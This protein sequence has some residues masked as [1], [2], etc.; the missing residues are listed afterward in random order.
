VSFDPTSF[1]QL[2]SVLGRD[3]DAAV[4]IGWATNE[5]DFRQKLVGRDIVPSFID[6]L[7]TQNTNAYF[8]INPSSHDGKGRSS[9]HEITR[10]VALWADVDFK[11]GGMRNEDGARQLIEELTRA[12]GAPPAAIVYSGGGCQPYWVLEDGDVATH[13]IE[14]ISAL[15]KRWGQ[16][17]KRFALD[18]GGAADGVFDLARVFRIP[19]TINVKYGAARPVT[20]EFAERRVTFTVQEVTDLLDE[21]NVVEPNT[22]LTGEVISAES[23]WEWADS[24]CQMV[25]IA[26]E[27]ISTS[28]PNSRHQ[29]SLKWS[30]ILYGMIRNGCITEASFYRLRD[31]L[32]ERFRW[33][34]Q[35][36]QNPRDVGDRELN[37]IFL[38]GQRR[39]EQWDDKKLAEEL[40]FHLHASFDEAW[41]ELTGRQEP[42][43]PVSPTPAAPSLPALPQATTPERS[44]VTSIASGLPVTF[45]QPE[46][47]PVVAT[48]GNLAAAL[49]PRGI[50]V[51][52]MAIGSRTDTGNAERLAAKFVGEFIYVPGMAWMRFDG[53][54][55]VRDEISAHV[56]RAKDVFAV[57]AA[58]GTAADQKWALKSMSSAGL[59][60]A[61]RLAQSTPQLA[62]SPERLDA[63][64]YQLC[65][66]SGI[67]DLR[68]GIMRAADPTTDLHT[69]Q[70]TVTPDWTVKP[71][72]FLELLEWMQP[73]PKIRAYLQRLAGIALIGNVDFQIFPIFIGPG[74]N[75]KTTLLELFGGVLGEYSAVMP[76]KFLVE[77]TH[78]DHP[79]EIAQLRGVRLAINSEVPATAKFDEDFVKTLTGERKLKARY[80][81]KDFF[82]FINTALQFMAA[83]HLPSVPAGGRGFWRR[84][85]K[86]NFAAQISG[87]ENKRLVP[88]LLAHEGAAI[89]AWMIDGAVDVIA[90]GEQQPQSVMM[91]TQQ[92]R[93]EEDSLARF[94]D[95]SL[96]RMPGMSVSRDA[97]YLN[98]RQW[99]IKEGVSHL[100]QPKFARELINQRPD[101][102]LE[103]NDSVY[104]NYVMTSAWL[105]QVDAD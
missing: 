47:Q 75:G 52:R 102:L 17:V 29:W 90:H 8:E 32:V 64:E 31:L 66:P 44:N 30:A 43:A 9:A 10:L 20:V 95:Q 25:S 89:L 59:S 63:E 103:D 82:D 28:V 78:N 73:D 34:C 94:L 46:A 40:R 15:S 85:R 99:A 18:L 84:V 60:A 55:Y 19:G 39:A 6:G 87:D 26:H 38:Y 45:A 68:T 42:A 36:T 21:Y 49:K 56:E 69:R 4:R 61:L 83:N 81:G 35:N 41:E 54:R 96:S 86:I 80:M 14:T 88:D 37:D 105:E 62:V 1:Y 101:A 67:V 98:Y 12:I 16:L 7:L 97:L 2:L 74:A 104:A 58:T 71:L 24:D 57:L 5:V 79:T 33:I 53:S 48:I 50:T 70:T 72:K 91:A 27:E 11:G 13:G 23:E 51:D 65:T 100:P 92:Y 22:G 77:K 76:K 3:N 93:Y